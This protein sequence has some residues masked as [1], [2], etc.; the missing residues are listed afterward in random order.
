MLACAITVGINEVLPNSC[1]ESSLCHA[2]PGT[3]LPRF[4]VGGG[5]LGK[6]G[7]LDV[8]ANS[9]LVPWIQ[10]PMRNLGKTS[11]NS[12]ADLSWKDG[13]YL[14]KVAISSGDTIK[15]PP[16]EHSTAIVR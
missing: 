16:P 6:L 12:S 7:S 2:V 1:N 3:E 13:I 15:E 5:G 4:L 8:L 10:A 11:D 9:C 14:I